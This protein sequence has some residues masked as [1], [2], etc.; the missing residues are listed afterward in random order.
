M[1]RIAQK[2]PVSETLLTLN[3]TIV[4]FTK[5]SFGLASADN[6]QAVEETFYENRERTSQGSQRQ[7]QG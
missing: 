2:F 3:Q 1:A 7:R 5:R 4:R 6:R